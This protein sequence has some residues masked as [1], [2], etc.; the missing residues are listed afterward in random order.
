MEFLVGMVEMSYA[1]RNPVGVLWIVQIW[2]VY[3]SEK[4]KFN[5]IF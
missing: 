3:P 4:F 5:E 1:Y 2:F